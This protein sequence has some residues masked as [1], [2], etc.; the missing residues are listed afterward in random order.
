MHN[1]LDE[2]I[3]PYADLEPRALIDMLRYAL[4]V[5]E[6]SPD[7]DLDQ[8]VDDLREAAL[9]LLPAAEFLEEQ[10]PLGEPARF[11]HAA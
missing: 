10:E 1:T 2:D 9:L 6:R 7:T 5:A 3:N 4:T 8:V 11:L